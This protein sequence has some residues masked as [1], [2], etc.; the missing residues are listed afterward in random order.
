MKKIIYS[1][2]IV[3][4]LVGCSKEQKNKTEPSEVKKEQ[5]KLSIRF[6]HVCLE[7]KIQQINPGEP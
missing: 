3:L 2:L 5:K 6:L 1:L 7:M 4:L